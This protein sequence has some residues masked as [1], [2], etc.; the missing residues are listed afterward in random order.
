MHKQKPLFRFKDSPYSGESVRQEMIEAL[1]AVIDCY[2]NADSL[3]MA[4]C[5]R[6]SHSRGPQGNGS[7]YKTLLRMREGVLFLAS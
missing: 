5:R 2:G 4:Q 1:E 3:I 7:C 6:A